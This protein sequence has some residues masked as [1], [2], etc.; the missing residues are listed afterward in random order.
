MSFDPRTAKEIDS[1]LQ[2]Y[3]ADP[4]DSTGSVPRLVVSVANSKEVLY[5]GSTGYEQLPP[6]PATPE[7]LAEAPKVSEKSIFELFSCTKLVATIAALQLLEQGVISSLEEDA[8]KWVPELKDVQVLEG[9]ETDGSTPRLVKSEG[10]V[11]V[12]D[13]ITHTSGRVSLF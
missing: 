6:H 9:W 12:R 3:T 4:Y 5:S 7:Q 13:L 8:S 2:R 11:T 1:L 10:V